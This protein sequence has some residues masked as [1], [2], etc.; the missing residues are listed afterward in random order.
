MKKKS[1]RKTI[2]ILILAILGSTL[3]FYAQVSKKT[4]LV[5]MRLEDNRQ[6]I[7]DLTKIVREK[8]SAS[9]IRRVKNTSIEVRFQPE[10]AKE[11]ERLISKLEKVIKETQETLFPLETEDLKL[12]ILQMN[13]IPVNYRMSE[14]SD[15][16][17]FYLH[18][19]VFKDTK[20]LNTDDCFNKEFCSEIFGTVSHELTHSALED[21]ITSKGTRWFDDGLAEYVGNRVKE[22]FFPADYQEKIEAYSPSVSL[23]RKEIRE[24]I[25]FWKEPELDSVLKINRKDLSNEIYKYGASYQIIKQT[26]ADAEKNGVK[27]PLSVLLTKLKDQREKLGKTVDSEEIIYLIQEYLMVN[28]KSLGV[29]DPQRQQFLIT[30]ALKIL[31]QNEIT[32]EKKNYELYTLAGIDSIPL[33]GEWIK[34]LLNVVYQPKQ[35]DESSRELAAAALAQRFN[36]D[37]FDTILE[38]Y[39][40]ENKEI[41]GKSL[42]TIKKQLQKLSIRSE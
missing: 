4:E 17:K 35:A 40:R 37:D 16:R 7:K 39:L 18:F 15:G 31:S 34:Y 27:N 20:E 42:K 9:I 41:K 1:V 32:S 26:I 38:D 22:K 19:A 24:N 25:W 29:L 14:T 6:E 36:Q 3:N 5:S 33:S 13:E 30:E 2:F 21:L 11:A 12:Y 23:N 28:P 10:Y 8:C